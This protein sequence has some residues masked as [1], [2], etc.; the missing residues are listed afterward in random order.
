NPL[1]IHKKPPIALRRSPRDLSRW[2]KSLQ[3]AAQ[4]PGLVR[5][6]PERAAPIVGVSQQVQRSFRARALGCLRKAAPLAEFPPVSCPFSLS[7]SAL[8]LPWQVVQSEIACS[9]KG[10]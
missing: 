5:H 8:P 10:L 4:N 7:G 2:P 3:K 9:V 6:V 1:A